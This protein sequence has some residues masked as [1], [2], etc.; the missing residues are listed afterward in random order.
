MR[1]KIILSVISI[2]MFSCVLDSSK[3]SHQSIPIIDSSALVG[4]FSPFFIGNYWRYSYVQKSFDNNGNSFY[5]SDSGLVTIKINSHNG[6]IVT[7]ERIDSLGSISINNG[8]TLRSYDNLDT[9]ITF[10]DT[11][12][13]NNTDFTMLPFCGRHLIKRGLLQEANFNSISGLAFMDTLQTLVFE[14]YLQNIGLIS[15]KGILTVGN[16]HGSNIDIELLDFKQNK[17]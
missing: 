11:T 16:G 2:L 8:D 5:S 4:D 1:K 12:E 3:D 14:T 7:I 17:I 13:W 10:Y 15:H 6:T 9:V